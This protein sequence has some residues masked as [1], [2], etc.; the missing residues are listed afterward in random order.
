MS[1]RFPIPFLLVLAMLSFGVNTSH[2]QE[3]KENSMWNAYLDTER[4]AHHGYFFRSDVLD[5]EDELRRMRAFTDTMVFFLLAHD[6]LT[7]ET[8]QGLLAG[9]IESYGPAEFDKARRRITLLES[10]DYVTMGEAPFWPFI[11]FDLFDEY[12]LALTFLAENV[13]EIGNLDYVYFWD[14]PDINPGPGVEA[15]EKYI[16]AFKETFPTVKVTTCYAIAKEKFLDVVPPRNLD[17]L[18]IDP[19]QLAEPRANTPTDFEAFYRTRLAL[20]LSWVNQW[21]KPFLLVGDSFG[22][23]T[24]SGKQFPSTE[25]SLWYYQIALLQPRC[26]GLLWFQYGEIDTAEN[27]TGVTLDGPPADLMALHREIGERIL[28]ESSRL[29]VPFDVG[30]PPLPEIVQKAMDEE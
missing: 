7:T 23:I 13:P 11:K 22:S 4:L 20:C 27:I 19:Y 24:G 6:D 10:M 26:T 14:E 3:P 16:D 12:V 25:A 9:K 17:L 8:V 30:P 2:A 1:I 29:G 5:H 18:M 15:L 21:D 28:G